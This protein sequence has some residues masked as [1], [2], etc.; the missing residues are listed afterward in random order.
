MDDLEH[1]GD[2]GT[3]GDHDKV[4]GHV[5]GVLEFALWAT[6]PDFLADF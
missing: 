6:N 3:T 4:R 2:T 1:G 5:G